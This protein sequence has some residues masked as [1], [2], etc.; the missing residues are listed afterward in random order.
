MARNRQIQFVNF[1]APRDPSASVGAPTPFRC[2][3]A[4]SG[5]DFEFITEFSNHDLNTWGD[6]TLRLASG[7]MLKVAWLVV[8]SSFG[9]EIVER[10][11]LFSMLYLTVP[12]ALR[13]REELRDWIDRAVRE[14]EINGG[15]A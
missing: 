3:L 7:L 2:D 13:S 1:Q 4:G 11:G 15:D 10:P 6:G 9:A 8:P 12:Q 5:W 14:L